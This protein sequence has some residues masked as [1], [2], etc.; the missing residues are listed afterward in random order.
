M[1]NINKKNETKFI[2]LLGD[3]MADYPSPILNNRTVLEMAR[4]PNMDYIA[5]QG[6]LGTVRT[7]PEKLA[8][9]SDVANL[10]ILGY[11]PEEFYTGR[12]PLEAANIGVELNLSDVAFRCN[13]VT[14][15]HGMMEDFSAGHISTEEA[16]PLIENLQKELGSEGMQF[17]TGTSYRHLFVWKKG[18][19]RI[20]C[21]PPHDISKKQIEKF[22]PHGEGSDTLLKLI[23]KSQEALKNH[24]INKKR[25]AEGKNPANSIWFWGQG[26][27]PSMPTFFEKYEKKGAIISAVDLLKGIGRYIGFD[28]IE[29]PGATGYLDTNYSGK[30]AY[31]VRS[32]EEK[33]FVYVHVEAPDEAGHN[34][35]LKGKIQAVEDFDEKIVGRVLH[36]VAQKFTSYR[37]MVL[38]DHYTPVALRTHT[39]EP[40]PFGIFPPF[41]QGKTDKKIKKFNENDAQ[42]GIY[43][44]EGY[45]LM[46]YFLQRR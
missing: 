21:T 27:T 6:I 25:K 39:S 7:I 11:N 28:I 34:G 46:D 9:G 24:P 3:G 8:P 16:R 38:P 12:A 33:N 2:I 13:L 4:T 22:L 41:G 31:A 35:D 1:K 43:F 10:S 5:Q 30:A 42:E 15:T 32:L 44:P 19:D 17:F 23:D 36:D 37:I 40:V 26:K 14:I 45:K 20:F 29:V 18:K